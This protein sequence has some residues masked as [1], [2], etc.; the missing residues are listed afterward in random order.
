MGE[1][2]CGVHSRVL[3]L[4]GRVRHRGSQRKERRRF[5]S[6]KQALA[7]PWFPQGD[8]CSRRRGH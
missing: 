3:A 6:H 4:R 1:C 8:R 5:S 7:L 2:A